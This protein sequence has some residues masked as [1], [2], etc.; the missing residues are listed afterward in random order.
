MCAVSF[1][2]TKAFDSVPHSQLLDCLKTEYGIPDCLHDWLRSYLDNRWQAVKVN[3]EISSWRSVKAGVIQG[4][5]IGPLLF[6]AYFDKVIADSANGG[7]ALK[8]ADDLLLLHPV[9]D[10]LGEQNLQRSID[11]MS[12]AMQAKCLDFSV[13]K[14]CQ[15]TI[16]ESSIPYLPQDTPYLNGV[17][18]EHRNQLD[19][20]GVTID[21]KLTWSSNSHKKV[22]KAKQAI[23]SIRQ[24]LKNKLPLAKLRLLFLTKILPIFTY[25]ITVTYPRNKADRICL[26]R[27]N[28]Y[29]AHLVTNDYR[30]PYVDLLEKAAMQPVF[31]SVLYQRI[32]LAQQYSKGRRYLPP[33][34]IQ[35]YSRNDGRPHRFHRYSLAACNATNLRYRDSGLELALQAWNRLPERILR[36]NV[37]N[38]K[39]RLRENSYED[40]AWDI[41]AMMYAAILQ[42]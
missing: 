10:L 33:R 14:C 2:I 13:R 6:I 38:V 37:S 34:T 7:I 26:E 31:E 3:D 18:V 21:S 8:Y 28:L 35:A 11:E 16:S 30:S 19:Y 23:G 12:V 20:L 5:V 41:Y 25:G 15:T 32:A 36:G 40:T 24:L 42:L 27:L 39:G 29:V 9:N 1:D 4:S 22:C 17:P